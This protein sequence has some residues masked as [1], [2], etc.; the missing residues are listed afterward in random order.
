[1]TDDGRPPLQAKGLLLEN[2]LGA[3]ADSLDRV[4][5]KGG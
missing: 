2:R 3:V 5:Q 1:L 4:D